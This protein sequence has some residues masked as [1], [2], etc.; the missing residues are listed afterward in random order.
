MKK[1][2]VKTFSRVLSRNHH[3]EKSSFALSNK[4]LNNFSVEITPKLGGMQT[5]EYH[6]DIIHEALQHSES[7]HHH[8]SVHYATT[9]LGKKTKLTTI[10]YNR[11]REEWLKLFSERQNY[12]IISHMG[13]KIVDV[14]KE[15]ELIAELTASINHM[16]PNQYMHAASIVFLADTACGFGCYANLPSVH[17][18]FTTIELKSNFISSSKVGKRVVCRA[19]LIH[20]GQSTQVWDALVFEDE[21]DTGK[22]MATF[23]CTQ[24]IM[25][26]RSKQ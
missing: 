11:T 20:A 12:G 5:S 15:G 18:K 25:D 1:Q 17:H 16:A 7:N 8:H 6:H 13:F 19:Q 9:A 26:P 22:L 23:R 4:A 3:S 10:F 2:V 24:I 21:L 14:P